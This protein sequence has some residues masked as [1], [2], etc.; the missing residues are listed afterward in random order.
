MRGFRKLAAVVAVGLVAPMIAGTVAPARAEEPAEI[1]MWLDTTSGAEGAECIAKA[2]IDPFNALGNGVTVKATMQANNWDATRTALAGG[3][4][5]DIVGTPG[6]SF[7]IQLALAGNLAELDDFAKEYA[8]ADRFASNSLNLGKANGKLYSIPSEIETLVLYYNKNLFEANGWEV[9]QTMDELMTLAQTIS[10]AG[11]IPF[12]HANAEWRPANEWFVGEFLNNGAGQ[13]KV[14]Q[15]LTG[16]IPWTDEAFVGPLEMLS[17]MQKNGWFMGGL[18]RYYTTTFPEAGAALGDGDAAMKIEGT[19]F[20]EDVNNYFGEAAGNENDWGW[21]HVPS[22]DGSAGYTLGIGQ[23]Y[24][25]N[26]NSKNKEG[27]AKFLDFYFNPETQAR[28]LS[29]CG[30]AAAPV[31]MAGQDLSAVDPRLTEMLAS[32]NEAYANNKYGYTTW[33][34]WPSETETYLIE[35]VEKVWS[36][37]MTV[38][39]YLAGMQEKFDAEK[40]AGALP[41]LP[42]R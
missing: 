15:A 10:D 41:P 18:D 34:F 29:D 21:S 25:I 36:G 2:A 23:T 39:E 22:A 6:P 28:L 37:D 8:W 12:A 20:V 31:D 38:Q 33:T 32:L 11:I 27:A 30:I 35:E 4:G 26:A 40:A 24:S 5:P 14:Y 3:A 7:A 13:E 1:S 17:T 42:A 9:P 16:E 19:W